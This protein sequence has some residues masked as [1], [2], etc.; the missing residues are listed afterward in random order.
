MSSEIFDLYARENALIKE[1][2]VLLAS[3]TTD[4]LRDCSQRL[5]AQLQLSLRENKQLVRHSDRQQAKLVELNRHLQQKTLEIESR[6]RVF[7]ELSQKLCKYLAPQVHEAIFSGR[8]DIGIATKRKKLTVFFSDIKDFTPTTESLQPE[9]LTEY[10]NEYF[11][12]LT[13]VAVAHGATIDKYVGDAMMVFFGDPETL[14]VAEDARNCVRMAMSMQKALTE[15]R[16]RWIKR[17][18]N[19]P[20]ET[21]MGINTGYCNVGNFGSEQRLSY[22]IIGPEVNVAARIEAAAE[23]N[24]ILLSHETYVHVADEIEVET[25]PVVNLK[26]I[27]RDIQTYAVIGPRHPEKKRTA[28]SLSHPSGTRVDIDTHALDGPTRAL[29]TQELRAILL[30]LETDTSHVR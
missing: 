18:F 7:E 21:R 22:T 23:A 25:R 1:I 5:L 19:R 15:L 26:G 6:G 30:H 29:L 24:G 12:L 16:Q 13:E 17:G 9:A 14:G 10:L 8:Q 27:N 11:S 4:G 28:F 3:D 20:F 2:E